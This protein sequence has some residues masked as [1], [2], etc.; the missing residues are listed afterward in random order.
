MFVQLWINC[1]LNLEPVALKTE[2]FSPSPSCHKDMHLL[3]NIPSFFM[4]SLAGCGLQFNAQQQ[5]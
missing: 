3:S 2:G 1:E 5:R 4:C